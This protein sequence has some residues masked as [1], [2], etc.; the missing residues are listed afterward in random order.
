[1]AYLID[2]NKLYNHIKAE[3]NPY[4][5]PF[6]GTAY[7]FGNKLMDHLLDMEVVEANPVAH[8]KWTDTQPNY[9]NGCYISAHVC[10][11]CHDYYTT[12]YYD[13]YFCPRCGARM[14]GE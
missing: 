9:H 4:G 2:R 1:M 6:K 3:I 12:E 13:L 10:S 14:D 5:K 11:N 8:A 7:E